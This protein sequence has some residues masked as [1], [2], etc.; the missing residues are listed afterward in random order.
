MNYNKTLLLKQ[1]LIIN[2]LSNY[3]DE[4]CLIYSIIPCKNTKNYLKKYK[5]V[6]NNKYKKNIYFS[7]IINKLCLFFIK[8]KNECDIIPKSFWN[9]IL[10]REIDNQIMIKINLILDDDDIEYIWNVEIESLCVKIK[11]LLKENNY[12]LSLFKYEFINLNKIYIYEGNEYSKYKLNINNLDIKMYMTI[13]SFFGGN[14]NIM[15]DMYTII[16]NQLKNLKYKNIIL[17]GNDS[18]NISVLLPNIYEKIFNIINNK[19]SYECAIKTINNI[20]N[21]YLKNGNDNLLKII[22]NNKINIIC[23]TTNNGLNDNEINI[24]K[25]YNIKYIL[26]ISSNIK[27]LTND[28][29]K[30]QKYKIRNIH[31]IDEYPF[32]TKR[33]KIIALL[34]I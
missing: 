20:S 7:E 10:F 21:I 22:S 11:D 26:Y 28:L 9:S 30:L 14:Y 2:S 18:A 29:F 19:K 31:S 16:Y 15:S 5:F 17:L 23:I 34:K 3:F 33:F 1:E 4:K 13:D 25:K 12:I 32:I 8:F 6:F 24:L 27:N